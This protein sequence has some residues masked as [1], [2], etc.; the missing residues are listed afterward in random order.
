MQ[1]PSSAAPAFIEEVQIDGHIIDSLLL[2]KVLDEILTRGGSYGLKDIKIGQ[3]QADPSYARIEVGSPT[4]AGL[5]EILHAIHEHGATP[6]NQQD[7][8][9]VA[10][11]LDGCFPEHFYSTTNQRTQ[12]R[13]QGE[14]IDVEDR[15]E[16]RRVGKECRL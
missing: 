13:L 16:E 6:V 1:S 11:D 2:P 14:W 10:A 4:A 9:A 12:V 7:C 5:Q 3:S 8:Q 15:S